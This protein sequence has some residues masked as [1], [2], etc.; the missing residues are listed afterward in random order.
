MLEGRI[1]LVCNLRTSKQGKPGSPHAGAVGFTKTL[2]CW[3]LTHD[4][5]HSKGLRQVHD[6]VLRLQMIIGNGAQKEL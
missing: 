2:R 4:M 6:P 3:K 5:W 1:P